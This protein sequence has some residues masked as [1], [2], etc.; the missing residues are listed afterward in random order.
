MDNLYSL[1]KI[2]FLQCYIPTINID[3]N[4]LH[5]L[6]VIVAALTVIALIL[7][8][9][10]VRDVRILLVREKENAVRILNIYKSAEQIADSITTKYVGF[11]PNNMDEIIKL[12]ESTRRELIIICDVPK[13]GHF[14]NP[15]GFD[16]YNQALRELLIGSNKREVTLIV[17]DKE[18]RM[19]NSKVQFNMP[20]KQ[21]EESEEYRNYF[22]YHKNNPVIKEPTE[23]T[24]DGFRKWLEEKHASI[25]EEWASLGIHIFECPTTF[26][27]YA[28]ISDD[29]KAVFSFYN[30]GHEPREVSFKTRDQSLIK[31]LK[32]I[33]EATNDD[34]EEYSL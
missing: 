6:E 34:V 23:K 10:T 8:I 24:L 18:Q 20:Y 1:S 4:L 28:W 27:F 2:G 19:Q 30:Y 3:E 11:F 31:I 12:I 16:R 26:R 25:I 9:V 21:I 32:N 7:A 14:S 33:A 29:H 17:Y 13:Y 15:W 5:I 22:K